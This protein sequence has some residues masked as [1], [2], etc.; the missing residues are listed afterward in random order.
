MMVVMF[1]MLKKYIASIWKKN[2]WRDVLNI[3]L[4]LILYTYIKREESFN[5]K[6]IADYFYF[7]S[8]QQK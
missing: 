6:I 4:E 2:I 7:K 5:I 8:S 3:F 1:Q